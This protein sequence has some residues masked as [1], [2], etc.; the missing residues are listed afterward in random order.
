MIIAGYLGGALRIVIIERAHAGKFPDDMGFLDF[1]GDIAIDGGQQIADLVLA[2]GG[3][4]RITVDRD[5][6]GPDH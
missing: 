1:G 6:G 3:L 4:F 2:G 5:V